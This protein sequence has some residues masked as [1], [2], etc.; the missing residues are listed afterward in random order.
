MSAPAYSYRTDPDVPKFDDQTPIAFM[1]GDCTLCTFGARMIDILDKSGDIRICPVQTPL[2]QA[3]LTHYNIKQDDPET[4]LVLDQGQTYQG[5]E[6]MI[7]VGRRSGGWG[8]VLIALEILPRAVRGW[9][10]RRIARNRYSVFGRTDMCAVA[11][12]GLRA[13][14]IK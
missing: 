12:P 7:H 3:V 11:G 4:W 10:Y 2:G 8:R 1:D 13:R 6:A 9:L 14:L 5:I